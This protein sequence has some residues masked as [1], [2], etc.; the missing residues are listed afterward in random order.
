MRY[1]KIVIRQMS[2]HLWRGIA[3]T[4]L[5]SV[6]LSLFGFSVFFDQCSRYN[7]RT[8]VELYGKK[9]DQV[10]CVRIEESDTSQSVY[11]LCKKIQEL[12]GVK[13]TG[14]YVNV[15]TILDNLGEIQDGHQEDDVYTMS[16]DTEITFADAEM[17]EICGVKFQKDAILPDS[18][19]EK[20]NELGIYLGAAFQG[21]VKQ[22]E[23]KVDGITYRVL[24]FMQKGQKWPSQR[25]QEFEVSEI[26]NVVDT[27]YKVIALKSQKDAASVLGSILLFKIDQDAS[28]TEVSEQ[29]KAEAT[30]G[31]IETSIA[32]IEGMVR[33][34]EIV[35]ESITNAIHHLFVLLFGITI[36]TIICQYIVLFIKDAK[37]YATMYAVGMSD[38]DIL[39]I[40]GIQ[41][42]LQLLIALA[43][44][45][46]AISSR[47]MLMIDTGK[48]KDWLKDVFHSVL[49]Q[50]TIPVVLLLV[51]ILFIVITM[52]PM[53]IF[54]RFSPVDIWKERRLKINL[55]RILKTKATTKQ[56]RH[57]KVWFRDR[58]T[59]LL[60][61]VSFIVIFVALANCFG[62]FRSMQMNDDVVVDRNENSSVE[63]YC[64]KN[65]V[66][67]SEEV[68]EPTEGNID[69]LFQEL[70][71]NSDRMAI[72]KTEINIGN[73][74]ESYPIEIVLSGSQKSGMEETLFV[75]SNIAKM[76]QLVDG[77]KMVNLMGVSIPADGE[78]EGDTNSKR[79]WSCVLVWDK[80]ADTD[81]GKILQRLESNLYHHVVQIATDL[82]DGESKQDFMERIKKETGYLIV[83]ADNEE[84]E[85]TVIAYLYENY[86]VIFAIFGALF[87]ICS[88]YTV[89][90][91]WAECRRKEWLIRRMVGYSIAQIMQV[92]MGELLRIV[93]T[94]GVLGAIIQWGYMH[95]NQINGV[96][97]IYFTDARNLAVVY[98]LI[99]LLQLTQCLFLLYRQKP[100]EL[101]KE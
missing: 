30:A 6:C 18:Y 39:I 69:K 8:S 89:F 10:G 101:A 20:D 93:V 29:I 83:P 86:S 11:E 19:V 77:K 66:S 50:G 78:I 3:A 34:R 26:S 12:P 56:S 87:A 14:D 36:L 35:N 100:I 4:V 33:N 58:S 25:L 37:E 32:S 61:L 47:M 27:D 28:F 17:F 21:K 67:D 1:M 90:S 81:Q 85:T 59:D 2:S 24:G 46:T 80:L 38:R 98:A 76:E 96:W 7:R 94:A 97:S 62:L 22:K 68:F 45:V 82:N 9:L 75:G 57:R 42:F 44:S 91:L 60:L 54:Q 43:L 53:L 79:A 84:A 92:I 13:Y 16:G 63:S 23:F 73:G 52:I 95:Y 70:S 55:P 74:M 40:T 64:L 31:N 15:G 51:V 65:T 48:N 99:L 71:N 5:L 88:S 72:L 41:N 49:Y